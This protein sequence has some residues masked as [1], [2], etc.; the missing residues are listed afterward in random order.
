M[1]TRRVGSVETMVS[2]LIIGKSGKKITKVH[3]SSRLPRSVS[4]RSPVFQ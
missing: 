2:S 1:G 4:Y 3:S